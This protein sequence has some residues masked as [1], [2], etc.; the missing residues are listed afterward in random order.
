[1]TI[2]YIEQIEKRRRFKHRSA[3][4]AISQLSAIYA[5]FLR[6]FSTSN[7]NVTIKTSALS[8]ELQFATEGSFAE[9]LKGRRAAAACPA[10]T[11]RNA[12]CN[13]KISIFFKEFITLFIGF[14]NCL[15]YPIMST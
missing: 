9:D 12:I 10:H 11:S 15:P 13:S 4:P 8:L 3:S 1:M 14:S 6:T 7:G 2:H 5:I